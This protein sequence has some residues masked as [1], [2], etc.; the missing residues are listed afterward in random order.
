[1][2][3]IV[4]SDILIY[5]L[6]QHPQVTQKFGTTDPDQI[7]TTIINYA[8]LLFGAYNSAKVQQNL[9]NIKS[10]LETISI[11]NFD[12]NAGEIFAQLKT[13][14]RKSGKVIAD[15]DLII[16]SICLS[17]D[18]ILVTNNIKHFGRIEELKIENWSS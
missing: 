10:F 13:N 14:L 12:K 18:F 1:M 5:F 16:A 3:Y 4:D 2:R 9:K 6:K 8:E 7:G 11:I 15:L 17:N